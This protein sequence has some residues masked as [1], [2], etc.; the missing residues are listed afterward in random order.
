[1]FLDLKKAFDTVNHKMLLLK[2]ESYGMYG[3][4]H[5]LLKS[6][7]NSKQQYTTN[8][9]KS[10]LLPILPLLFLVYVNDLPIASKFNTKLFADNTTLTMSNKRMDTLNM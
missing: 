1:V 5:Q 7:L 6:Y 3:L 8:G 2:L 10:N 9:N 4:P